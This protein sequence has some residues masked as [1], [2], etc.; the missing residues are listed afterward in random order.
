MVMSAEMYDNVAMARMYRKRIYD[1]KNPM[2]E[3]MD[4]TSEKLPNHK[5]VSRFMRS[6]HVFLTG[7]ATV[8]DENNKPKEDM[9][10]F[11]CDKDI[12]DHF[13]LSAV[14]MLRQLSHM[15]KKCFTGRPE[16]IHLTFQEIFNRIWVKGGPANK[17]AKMMVY[18]GGKL[19]DIPHTPGM[20]VPVTPALPVT[21]EEHLGAE[22][23]SG[24]SGNI[25]DRLKNM[26]IG[27]N[28]AVSVTHVATAMV[29]KDKEIGVMSE[30]G[31]KVEEN[32]VPDIQN[33]PK[34]E[35]KF[36]EGEATPAKTRKVPNRKGNL[37]ILEKA[38][39]GTVCV[40]SP[41][42]VDKTV[43]IW[44][45]DPHNS[46]NRPVVLLL[47]DEYA[48][49]YGAPSAVTRLYSDKGTHNVAN[50]FA[51]KK[52]MVGVNKEFASQ[53]IKTAGVRLV[54]C[55]TDWKN[56]PMP[57]GPIDGF[58]VKAKEFKKA[59]L[60]AKGDFV[61]YE[62]Y[63]EEAN[64]KY[65]VEQEKLARKMEQEKLAGEKK[66]RDK[67]D[68]HTYSPSVAA[69]EAAKMVALEEKLVAQEKRIGEQD[70]VI[71]KMAKFME[72]VIAEKTKK[73]QDNFTNRRNPV[74][75]ANLPKR[76]AAGMN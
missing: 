23:L 7:R 63:I 1:K 34:H 70:E 19:F 50:K 41:N 12:A 28:R 60:A 42:D 22:H 32:K 52:S 69:V 18:A 59:M 57:L 6:L 51:L 14:E 73:G 64:A 9:F 66:S 62:D 76:C 39:I 56:R 71:R 53:A 45:E 31:V 11:S 27:C 3:V 54:K 16:D 38:L 44:C 8:Y 35:E 46:K 21:E 47:G 43:G 75:P 17:K 4:S 10:D 29:N 36:I 68:S 13:F 20:D 5:V 67:V 40:I 74:T 65:T 24:L 33:I 15:P 2:V 26:K 49:Y 72:D 58:E 55:N 37:A 25:S 30:E 61:R 48:G